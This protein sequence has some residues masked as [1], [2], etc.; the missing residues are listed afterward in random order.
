MGEPGMGAERGARQALPIVAGAAAMLTIG[1]GMRQSLGIFMLPMTRDIALTI[2][3]FTLAIAVQNLVWGLLQPLAGAWAVRWGFRPLMIGGS[4][5][6]AIGLASLACAH[7]VVAVALAAGVAIGAAMACTGVAIALA[8]SGRVVAARRRS[9]VFGA[10]AAA[11]SLGAS[12]VA[13]IA[14]ALSAAHGWRTGVAAFAL[15]SLAMLPTAWLAGRV[16]RIAPEASRAADRGARAVVVQALRHP[17]FVV[18][19]GAYFVCGMQLVF[20][21]THLP[22]YLATCGMDPMLGAQALGMIGAFNVLGSLFFGWAGGRANRLLLL[23][24]IYL[25]RSLGIAWF[26]S[27]QPTTEGTLAFAA[28]MGFLWFGVSPLVDGTIAQTFGLRWQAMLAGVAFCSHQLGSFV[29]AYGGGMV[30]DAFGSYALAW[31]LGVGLGFAA[32]AVQIVFAVVWPPMQAHRAPG[33][34]P[35]A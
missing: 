2:S 19:T 7:G 6:Y 10:V 14:Q 15:L 9:L 35:N 23:G 33:P 13:P 31:R 4:L 17:P 26:F 32:G 12:F 3:Q 8:V 27:S 34:Q 1:L 24:G 20:L 28:V 5:L 29:G 16:D 30:F 18:M 22:T 11:G 21:T 25:L